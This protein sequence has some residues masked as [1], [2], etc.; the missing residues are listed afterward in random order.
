MHHSI[1]WSEE[2]GKNFKN[3]VVLFLHLLVDFSQRM[4]YL[5]ELYYYKTFSCLFVVKIFACLPPTFST[6]PQKRS[7]HLQ[8]HSPLWHHTAPPLSGDQFRPR[9]LRGRAL[10]RGRVVGNFWREMNHPVRLFPCLIYEVQTVK[11]RKALLSSQL[12]SLHFLHDLY[13]L[14]CVC[15]SL[16]FFL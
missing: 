4:R 12:K 2:L 10:K 8:N 9:T 3:E 1:C 16:F 5:A 6:I 15:A 14:V 11:V 13:S 7:T